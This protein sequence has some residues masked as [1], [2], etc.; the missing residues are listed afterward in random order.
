M[1]TLVFMLEEPSAQDALQ[2]LLPSILPTE[3]QVEYMIF[4]G[5]QDLEKRIGRRMRAW[6]RPDTS[7]VVLRDQDNGDCRVIKQGLTEKCR[8]AGRPDTLVRIACR[9]LEA[10]F[11]GDWAAVAQGFSLPR[12]AD[13]NSKAIYREPDRL[14]N[15]VAELRKA[16]PAYQKRDGARRIGAHLDPRRNCSPSFKAFAEA[17][18]RLAGVS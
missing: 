8:D 17:V 13:W 2:G 4:E 16:I 5:K 18:R 14:G 7:F 12:V 6:L 11:V 9:E 1:R 10:W 3:I 15:P